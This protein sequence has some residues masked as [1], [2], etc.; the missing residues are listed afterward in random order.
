MA[1]HRAGAETQTFPALFLHIYQTFLL[2]FDLL[3]PR[4]HNSPLTMQRLMRNSMGAIV[5]PDSKWTGLGKPE[6]RTSLCTMSLGAF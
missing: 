2:D 3:R 4:T 6:P 5:V 1:P